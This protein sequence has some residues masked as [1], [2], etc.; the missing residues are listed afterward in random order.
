MAGNGGEG[1]SF[2]AEGIAKG[3]KGPGGGMGAGGGIGPE[4]G[5]GTTNKKMGDTARMGPGGTRSRQKAGVRPGMRSKFERIY[6]PERIATTP[7]DTKV[8]GKVGSKGKSYSVTVMGEPDAA[9]AKEG[10]ADVSG[11][12]QHAIES[13]LTKEDI[14]PTYRKPVKSYF[15]S[16]K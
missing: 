16:L 1:D 5:H 14:P 6:D 7:L 13:A 15:E 2:S 3:S 9:S 8:K 10:Y 4:A 11:K 12:Y